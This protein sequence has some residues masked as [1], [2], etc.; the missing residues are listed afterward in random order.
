M[1]TI[2]RGVL[3]LVLGAVLGGIVNMTLVV[4]GPRI[5]PP[6]P[7]V[8]MTTT[9]GL[10]ASIHLLRPQHFIFPFLAHALGTLAGAL[11]AYRIAVRGRAGFAYGIGVLFLAGGISAAFMIPAPAW[12]L[13]LDLGVAYLPM[14]WVAVRV[15]RRVFFRE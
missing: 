5:I 15:G 4:V 3:A 9:A 8:D 7:G 1:K 11:A 12:F 14:A 10:S 2:L 13:V 6:P